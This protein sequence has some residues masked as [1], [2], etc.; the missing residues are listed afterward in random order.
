MADL[1]PNLANTA[2]SAI[3]RQAEGQKKI[4]QMAKQQK[5]LEK[6]RREE[7]MRDAATRRDG[8]SGR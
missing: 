1:P 2:A 3:V 6:R 4:E 8:T 7:A 5:A